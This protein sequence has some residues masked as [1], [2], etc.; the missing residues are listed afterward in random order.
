M[1]K[2]PLETDIPITSKTVCHGAACPGQ[3]SPEMLKTWRRESPQ[4]CCSLYK[5]SDLKK[6]KSSLCED[7]NLRTALYVLRLLLEHSNF[8]L[9]LRILPGPSCE[10]WADSHDGCDGHNGHNAG[11]ERSQRSRRKKRVYWNLWCPLWEKF[12]QKKKHCLS[13][14]D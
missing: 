8:I 6:K 10:T 5:K 12:P 14:S 4:S 7:F 13:D 9:L 2:N 3:I 11:F 1:F